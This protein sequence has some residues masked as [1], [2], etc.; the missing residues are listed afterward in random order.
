[1][2]LPLKVYSEKGAISVS[3]PMGRWLQTL[4]GRQLESEAS[5]GGHKIILHSLHQFCRESDQLV[6][7]FW[8]A[9]L[10]RD[11]VAEAAKQ[12]EEKTYGKISSSDSSK[13]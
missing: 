10:C 3:T 7:A 11:S 12:K 5:E 1:M 8:L 6:R 2:G 4:A 9:T 13:W